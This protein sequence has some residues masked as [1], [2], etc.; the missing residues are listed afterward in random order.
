MGACSQSN[1]LVLVRVIDCDVGQTDPGVGRPTVISWIENQNLKGSEETAPQQRCASRCSIRL[2][3]HCELAQAR[4]SPPCTTGLFAV[5]GFVYI[6][7]EVSQSTLSCAGRKER[8]DVK[9]GTSNTRHALVEQTCAVVMAC[10][11]QSVI[12]CEAWAQST[13][14]HRP[15]NC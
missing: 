7:Y 6:D 10:I 1:L 11:W 13:F 14:T 5:I 4:P 15:R 2:S 3:T 9:L 12:T 8:N